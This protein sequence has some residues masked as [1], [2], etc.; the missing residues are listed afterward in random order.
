VTNK[1]RETKLKFVEVHET[2]KYMLAKVVRWR[3]LCE[4]WPSTQHNQCLLFWTI[5]MPLHYLSKQLLCIFIK[6]MTK[7]WLQL[8]VAIFFL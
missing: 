7:L 5:L 8:L 3:K 1:K 4:H 2:N 6:R